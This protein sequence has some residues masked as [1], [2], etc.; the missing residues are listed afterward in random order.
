MKRRMIS[1]FLIVAF[2]LGGCSGKATQM[3]A[4]TAQP[5]EHIRLPMG[6][7]PNVQ[8]APFYVAAARGYYADEGLEIEFDYSFE[9]D[10]MA[11]VGANQLPFALVSGEQVLLARAQGLPV[12]YVMTWW[13]QYPVAIASLKSAGIQNP[14]DLRDK[15]IGVPGLFGASYVGLRALMSAGG[16]TEEDVTIDSIGYNQVEALVA[17]KEDAVVVYFNNEPLQLRSQGYELNVMRVADY[18]HLASNGLVTNETVMAQNPELVRRMI[19]ATLRGLTDTL[20]DPDT[21][22]ELC[23]KYVEGLEGEGSA[24]PAALQ[25]EVLQMSI[26]FWKTEN[27]G[28][29]DVQAWANMQQVLLEMGLL[30]GPVDL[31]KAYSNDFLGK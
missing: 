10:G 12:T 2:V 21:A 30:Q 7:I 28:L 9:T 1:M 19:R 27:L 25:K 15:R 24:Q 13:Q 16:L 22:F 31:D 23:K 26:E 4:G 14:A 6:Y 29:S 5:L 20:K 17:A 11:L 3:P 18:V 8:Y